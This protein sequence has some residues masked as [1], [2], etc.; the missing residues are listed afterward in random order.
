MIRPIYVA[1][2]LQLK[3]TGAWELVSLER[4]GYSHKWLIGRMPEVQDIPCLSYQARHAIYTNDLHA[5][6]SVQFAI[7]QDR[8]GIASK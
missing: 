5:P 2:L 1:V 3:R 4:A 7:A 6:G 8:S